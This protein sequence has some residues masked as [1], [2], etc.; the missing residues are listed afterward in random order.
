MKGNPMPN[1]FVSVLGPD[2]HPRKDED[3]CFK[4]IVPDFSTARTEAG[5][6]NGGHSPVLYRVSYDGEEFYSS[7]QFD[8]A[9]GEGNESYANEPKGLSALCYELYSVADGLVDSPDLGKMI[10]TI[11]EFSH[12][13][14]P[15]IGKP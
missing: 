8:I 3:V 7:R 12:Q 5:K 15:G 10:G 9:Q 14:R 2:Q 13:P 1:R 4:K 6:I 11:R